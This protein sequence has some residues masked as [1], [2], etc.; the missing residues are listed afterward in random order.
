MLV[1]L[2]T[3]ILYTGLKYQLLFFNQLYKNVPPPK[4][5]ANMIASF[6]TSHCTCVF[7]SKLNMKPLGADNVFSCYEK[8]HLLISTHQLIIKGTSKPGSGLLFSQES[9]QTNNWQQQTGCITR[10]RKRQSP[11]QPVPPNSGL[12]SQQENN[13]Q[14]LTTVH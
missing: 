8:L 5:I 2:S 13:M 1:F 11:P 9:Q 7:N 10:L 12:W 3:K 4:G 6:S 14:L